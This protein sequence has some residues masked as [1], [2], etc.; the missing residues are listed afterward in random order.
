MKI[1]VFGKRF[2]PD[3]IG[4]IA[5][6]TG[7]LRAEG[8]EVLMDGQ[9]Y[10]YLKDATEEVPA[11]DDFIIGDVF[12]ADYALSIG[13][14]G[15]FL[16]TARRVGDKQIPILGINTGRLG[17]LSAS[18]GQDVDQVARDLLSGRV[19]VEERHQ[20]KITSDSYQFDY[21]HALNEIAL[22]KRDTA[23]MLQIQTTVNGEYLH[24]YQSD[25]LLLSTATGSTAY[26]LS[27]GGPILLPRND[28]FIMVPVA[29]HSLTIRP[30]V[31]G[32]D[33][34]VALTVISRSKTFLASLDGRS[35]SLQ[36][37]MTF[38]IGKSDFPVR[39][40]RREGQ[41]FLQTLRAKMM[42][43]KD[44]RTSFEV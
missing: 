10:D 24:D 18:D 42:W 9:F 8:A 1:A 3:S 40:V 20:L 21:P 13:G 7:L 43:G 30:L 41:S 6:L 29:P 14:D 4:N 5:R 38:R 16:N 31:L 11:V 23:A 32:R 34:V 22:T 28:G 35:H 36:A 12:E 25:G 26:S 44:P 27:V 17:F 39:I 15:T 33:D 2:Q 19:I 37:P